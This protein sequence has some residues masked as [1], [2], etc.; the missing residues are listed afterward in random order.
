[1]QFY[2]DKN[3]EVLGIDMAKPR[4]SDHEP[5]FKQIDICDKSR[6]VDCM[7]EFL[8][9]HVIHL[10][11]RTD[12]NGA[13]LSD[14]RA[15]TTGTENV[16]AAI[17]QSCNVSKA[18]FAS[19]M[20]VCETGYQPVD[21]DDYKPSTMYGESKVL[22]EKLIKNHASINCEWNIVRPTSIWGP[23]FGEPYRNFFDL[24]MRRRYVNLKGRTATK[25]FGYVGNT[26]Y[27]IDQLL[28]S[29]DK[30][31]C[32]KTFYI[33]DS[34]PVNISEWADEILLAM[35]MPPAIRLPFPVFKML[36]FCGDWAGKVG[37]KIPMNSF[38]LRNMTTNNIQRL[39]D[40]YMAVGMPP[41]SR[42]EGIQQTLEWLRKQKKLNV[43]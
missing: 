5:Y 14:Y 26:V 22:A 30:S 17:N 10:A 25:T 2:L 31:L 38:R 7:C 27:Q 20:L 3:I 43:S 24:V 34:P 28:F 42:T 23:W 1:M 39:E 29:Q 33:G 21:S 6:L 13:T 40:L 18:L 37:V 15:N 4:N 8:P 32:R 36:A 16:I 9:T 12:L 35:G 41:Y 11:A 19:S